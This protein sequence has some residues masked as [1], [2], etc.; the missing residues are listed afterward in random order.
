MKKFKKI[1]LIL[2]V[3]LLLLVMGAFS[4]SAKEYD[5]SPNL[6]KTPGDVIVE[7]G[8]RTAPL[9]TKKG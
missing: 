9:G 6:L 8:F 4:V 2:S 3:T 5:Y 7:S 1:F